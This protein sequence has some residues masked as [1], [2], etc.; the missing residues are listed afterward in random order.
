MKLGKDKIMEGFHRLSGIIKENDEEFVPGLSDS[1]WGLTVNMLTGHFPGGK[2]IQS[3][4]LHNQDVIKVI[5]KLSN[6][7]VINMIEVLK[8]HPEIIEKLKNVD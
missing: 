3:V 8:Q 5:S 4:M 1:E 6:P 2:N 7:E